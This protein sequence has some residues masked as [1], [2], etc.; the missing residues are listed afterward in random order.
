MVQRE[1]VLEAL[2]KVRDPDL[3]R[4]IVDLGFVKDLQIDAGD[5]AFA[6]ELTTPACPV[7]ERMESE[8]RQLVAGPE[9][10]TP[11]RPDAERVEQTRID[12]VHAYRVHGSRVLKQR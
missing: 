1:Q 8:A 12:V 6:I 9:R 11:A 7:K 2:R 10:P 4:D 5:V 3:G